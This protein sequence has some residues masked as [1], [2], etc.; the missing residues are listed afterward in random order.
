MGPYPKFRST[1]VFV[2]LLLV[3]LVVFPAASVRALEISDL[4]GKIAF[5]RDGDV[6]IADLDGRNARQVTNTNGNIKEGYSPFFFSPTLRYLAYSKFLRYA[7]EL[8]EE[9]NEQVPGQAVHSIVITD[10]TNQKPVT[11][12]LPR[13]GE[14]VLPNGWLP[15]D[16][17]LFHE[18]SGGGVGD[19]FE[20]DVRQNGQRTVGIEE[21]SHLYGGDFHQDGS[22]WAYVTDSGLGPQSQQHLHLADLH[23][24][25][26]RILVSWRQLGPARLGPEPSSLAK[27]APNWRSISAP[28]ISP[29][30]KYVA[31]IEMEGVKGEYV[32]TLWIVDTKDGSLKQLYKG[33]IP[34]Q[35]FAWSFDDG[36][37][38]ILSSA[39]RIVLAVQNPANPQKFQGTD[40]GW[41]ATNNILCA[42]ENSL[43][44]YNV[45]TRQYQLVLK[46]GA[47]PTFLRRPMSKP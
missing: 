42:Q 9:K 19:H 1:T 8:D 12:I 37:I 32:H 17:L 5:L 18:A 31:F 36:F 16:K 3:G 38:A 44:L 28:R 22:L 4:E 41:V 46:N 21:A 40:C 23:S 15:N 47:Q 7:L 6:W 10:L 35:Q 13:D 43:Y 25:R 45:T 30:K 2:M 20:Y 24:K 34:G 29:Q 11:E 26:D 33:K 39:E 27:E 14:F